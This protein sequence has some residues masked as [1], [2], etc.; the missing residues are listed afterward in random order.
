MRNIFARFVRNEL[1]FLPMDAAANKTLSALSTTV[2]TPTPGN[3]EKL[4]DKIYSI[5]QD[6]FFFRKV[7][8]KKM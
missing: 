7:L 4:S 6:L 5:V 8:M 3:R 2:P 1:K